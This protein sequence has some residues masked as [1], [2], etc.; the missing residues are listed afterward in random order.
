MPGVFDRRRRPGAVRRHGQG[1]P[2]ALHR[3]PEAKGFTLGLPLR[4]G[5]RRRTTVFLNGRRIGVNIDPYTP[6]EIAATGLSPGRV[7]ELVVTV[8]S[9][10]DPR[11]P[12]G[13]WNWGGITRPV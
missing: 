9:R 5:S 11:L 10:K 13:W 4:A 3:A 8:D 12:E 6:F 7:N 2:A 1:V